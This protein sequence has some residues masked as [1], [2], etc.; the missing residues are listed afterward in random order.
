MR[1]A[2]LALILEA[3]GCATLPENP[4]QGP[5]GKRWRRKTAARWRNWNG[6]AAHDFRGRSGFQLLNSNS[7]HSVGDWRWWIAPN[8]RWT[9]N[10]ISGLPIPPA[11]C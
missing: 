10:I 2:A 7:E 4:P 8:I 6:I 5:P 3:A 9:C 11:T 1:Y